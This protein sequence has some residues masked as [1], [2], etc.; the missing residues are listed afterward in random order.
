MTLHLFDGSKRCLCCDG[1]ERAVQNDPTGTSKLRR[2]FNLFLALRWRQLRSIT[3]QIIVDQDLLQLRAGGLLNVAGAAILQGGTKTQA[4]QAWFDHALDQLVLG[5]DGSTMRPCITEAY[6]EGAAYAQKLVGRVIASQASSHR[7]DA[8][9]RL[10]VIELQG[11]MEAV[12][13]QAVRAVANGLLRGEKAHAIVADINSCIDRVGLARTNAMV[14]FMVVKSFNDAALDIFEAAGIR[15]VALVPEG[16][17]PQF[18]DAKKKAKKSKSREV[19]KPGSKISRE[20]QPSERTIRRIKKAEQAVEKLGRV[21]VVTA[22]DDKVC[23][24]CEDIADGGPYT[25]N[26]ARS[27]IPAHPRCRCAFVPADDK[28]YRKRR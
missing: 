17:R 1:D 20:R 26:M 7:E 18:G 6:V 8:L 25:I 13:Q 2:R 3:R 15:E 9:F 23:Q 10:A 22:G 5:R 27:L 4:F 14:E 21:Y 24:V 28:R 12:S 19:K 16:M 11:V